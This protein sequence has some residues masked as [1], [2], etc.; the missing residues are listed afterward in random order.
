MLKQWVEWA[1][2]KKTPPTEY[3]QKESRF[4]DP[5]RP[6]IEPKGFESE[7]EMQLSRQTTIKAFRQVIEQSDFF[8]FTLGLKSVNKYLPK[9]Y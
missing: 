1:L 2:D 9:T 7:E 8:V 4:Y 3:W 5:F 6:N